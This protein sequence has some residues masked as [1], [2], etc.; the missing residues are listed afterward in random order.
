MI[1]EE[2]LRK[3]AEK[4]VEEKVGFYIHFA[5]YI[6]VN[7]LLVT[8]WYTSTGPKSFPWFIYVTVGW[9]IGIVVHFVAAFAGGSYKDKLIVKEYEKLRNK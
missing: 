1:S 3:K 2:E 5:V 9:G 7:L 8:I 4:H 6:M